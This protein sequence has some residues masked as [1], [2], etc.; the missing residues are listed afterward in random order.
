MKSLIFSKKSGLELLETDD[1]KESGAGKALVEV[2]YSGI[3]YKDALGVCG[4]APIFKTDPLIP[5]I[6]LAGL[7]LTG[8]HSGKKVIAQACNIGEVFDGGYT[9]K[10]VVDEDL[11][12]PLPKGL[13]LK[14]SMILG[15]AGLTAA[16]SFHRME[17]NGQTP[18]KG[19]ILI[20][21]ATGGVGGFATQIFSKQG[22]EVNVVTHR[23]KYEKKLKNLGAKKVFS[24]EELF[25]KDKK[26]L[27][28]EKAKW[29]GVIDNLGGDFLESVLPQTKLWGNVCSI[30][31]AKNSNFNTSVMPFILRG[32]SLLGV[33]SNNCTMSLRNN[34]WDRLGDD[35]KPKFS[36]DFV[37]DVVK[38]D[39]VLEASKKILD[40]K[41]SGRV[42]VDVKGS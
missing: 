32:V 7:A 19:P 27:P 3:N 26:I 24:Y 40:H 4:K 39:G 15:T 8:K 14:E 2:H 35:L 1:P 22:Y 18:D 42:L 16:L 5:G 23:M 30:G 41:S 25:P 36:E 37:S 10:A 21:G 28:L 12:M 17:Q 6:D 34:L 20:S 31:L 38:L 13:S 11:L 9:Q 29:G 33:S